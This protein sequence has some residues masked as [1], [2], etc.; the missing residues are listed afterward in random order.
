[1]GISNRALCGII[2]FSCF[3][4]SVLLLECPDRAACCV[5][6]IPGCRARVVEV[7]E[8]SLNSR[9]LVYRIDVSKP[10]NISLFI[11]PFAKEHLSTLGIGWDGHLQH[12]L[13]V[14][15]AADYLSSIN[16]QP[17]RHVLLWLALDKKSQSQFRRHPPATKAVALINT[18]RLFPC[19]Q[20]RYPDLITGHE[21]IRIDAQL[22]QRLV[23]R[24][25]PN[26]LPEVVVLIRD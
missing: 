22:P 6:Q 24:V 4:K 9:H 20:L 5:I 10:E 14:E 17:V 25:I 26:R 1:M 8:A 2:R 19:T 3:F 7:L 15:A 11:L 12:A 13:C 16:N 23:I 21:L 18:G